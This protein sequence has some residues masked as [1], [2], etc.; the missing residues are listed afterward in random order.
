M[1][2]PGLL[3]DRGELVA[4]FDELATELDQLGKAAEIVMVGGS[5]MLWHSQRAATQDVDSA[6]RFTTDLSDAIGRVGPR[7]HLSAHWLN[8]NAAAYWPADASF[9]ECEIVYERTS[10]VVRTPPAD[11]IFVMKLYRAD[12]QDREDMINLWPL[13]S[14]GTPEEAADA[15]RS[16]YPH[17]PDDEQ[18]GDYI[19][20]IAHDAT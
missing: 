18:L 2:A 12:P 5:W 4:L 17:A 3:N 1:P 14:F 15:F 16:G 19:R 8:D 10:L 20:D 9:D 6:R 7:H 13:C 11:V